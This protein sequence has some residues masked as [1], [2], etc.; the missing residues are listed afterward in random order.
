MIDW[1]DCLERAAA[2]MA[3]TA[4]AVF[5]VDAI[6]SMN[7]SEWKLALATVLSAGLSVVKSSVAS[8]Y[9]KDR[10]CSLINYKD[11]EDELLAAYGESES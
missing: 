1:K 11:R 10:S 6:T 8:M 9:G 5:S 2:T 4:A 7:V 3:Q